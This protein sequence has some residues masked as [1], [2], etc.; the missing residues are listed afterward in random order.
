MDE[1]IVF[2]QIILQGI[3][4]TIIFYKLMIHVYKKAQKFFIMYKF[5]NNHPDTSDGS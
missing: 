5:T 4:E 1:I 2:F 3:S